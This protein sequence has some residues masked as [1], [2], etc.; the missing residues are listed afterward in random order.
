MCQYRDDEFTSPPRP[1]N[2]PKKEGGKEEK[3]KRGGGGRREEKKKSVMDL[4]TL[5][6]TQMLKLSALVL[7]NVAVFG[8]RTFK[9]M[10]KLNKAIRPLDFSLTV[11]FVIG[12]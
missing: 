3:G 5:P 4:I 6:K 9:Q 12:D 10:I 7:Q 11:V 1:E 2:L 8:D